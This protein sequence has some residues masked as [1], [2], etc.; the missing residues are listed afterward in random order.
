ME[1][2][3]GSLGKA[4]RI[5]RTALYFWALP[6]IAGCAHANQLPKQPA[7]ARWADVGKVCTANSPVTELPPTLRGSRGNPFDA[8]ASRR[9]QWA[10]RAELAR[11]V[12]GGWGGLTRGRDG[13]GIYLV[14]TTKRVAA[15]KALNEQGFPYAMN[16]VDVKAGRWDYI[17]MYDWFR[18]INT[19]L[20]DVRVAGWSLDEGR[21]R[22]WYAVEDK[23]S[24]LKLE[25]QL[26]SL[27]APCWLVFI[28]VTGPFILN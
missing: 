28:E 1:V 26:V 3:L 19:H 27:N 22:L 6:A 4:I 17:Q 21:N 5:R 18:Y 11:K 15:I 2:F 8:G 24:A 16:I 20:H 12:P 25:Q 23:D 7:M 14:D 10:E 9:D 13:L